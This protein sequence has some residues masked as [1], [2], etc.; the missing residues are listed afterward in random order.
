[1]RAIAPQNN[2]S[3]SWMSGGKS[4]KVVRLATPE[5][6]DESGCRVRGR[7]GATVDAAVRLADKRPRKN[8]RLPS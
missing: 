1:M 6:S 5:Q 2:G 3:E 7:G 4:S 8:T